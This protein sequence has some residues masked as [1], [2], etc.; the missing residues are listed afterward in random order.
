[1]ET[2]AIY[3][4]LKACGAEI[5]NH[6]SDLYVRETPETTAIIARH[7][8]YVASRFYSHGVLWVELPFEFAPWWRQRGCTA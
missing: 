8:P 5:D 6:E 1:M 3:D 4:E 2:R 7:K